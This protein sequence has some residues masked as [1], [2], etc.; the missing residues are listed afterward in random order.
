M[1]SRLKKIWISFFVIVIVSVIGTHKWM[2]LKV[3][4]VSQQVENGGDIMR[5]YE[6][7][8]IS[9]VEFYQKVSQAK[10]K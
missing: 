4:K 2:E 10:R 9:F 7:G 5:Q 1:R 3:I 6:N 8:E